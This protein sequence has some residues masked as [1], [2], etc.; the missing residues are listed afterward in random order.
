MPFYQDT[1]TDASQLS[2]VLEIGAVLSEIVV[3]QCGPVTHWPH[4]LMIPTTTAMNDK[5]LLKY[6]VH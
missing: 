6:C 1:G 2:A 3:C 4:A 5:S